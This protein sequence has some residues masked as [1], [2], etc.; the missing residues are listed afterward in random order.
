MTYRFL[1]FSF[2]LLFFSC[3]SDQDKASGTIADGI[4][5]CYQPLMEIN[6]KVQGLLKSGK[7]N[8]AEGLIS[9]MTSV[10]NQ[11]KECTLKLTK[12]ARKDKDL[13]ALKLEESIDESCPKIWASV[14]EL[15]FE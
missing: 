10:N 15:L 14:K 5:K 13:D 6:D 2:L 11:A 3:Q 1:L 12:D 9:E 4:C 7:G 8:Q